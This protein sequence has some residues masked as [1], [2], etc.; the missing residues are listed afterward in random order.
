MASSNVRG[1]VPDSK[2]S[3]R[4]PGANLLRRLGLKIPFVRHQILTLERMAE[5][6][7][8]LKVLRFM[9]EQ[10]PQTQLEALDLVHMRHSSRFNDPRRLLSFESKI[11]SQNGEDGILAEVFRR[12]GTTQKTFVE[13]GVGNGLEC[14]TAFLVACGWKGHWIDSSEWMLKTI[15]SS[16]GKLG[17]QVRAWQRFVTAENI[18][19]IF[20]EAGIAENFDLLSID[21]DQNTYYVW[22]ALKMY[23]PRVVVIEYNSAIP[24]SVPWKVEYSADRTWDGTQNFGASLKSLELLADDLGYS[25][26]GCDSTGTNAF[27]VL[28][29]LCLDLFASPYT[30][31]NHYEPRRRLHLTPMRHQKTLFDRA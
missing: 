31:E 8:Q 20:Q 12:I 9:L 11:N 23:K 6:C 10:L 16:E 1:S 28:K 30:A 5:V 7:D 13:I 15:E 3:E 4:N 22:A 27:F 25:L 2:L 21:V 18:A 19:G 14:N 24:A 29:E 17:G 26:V